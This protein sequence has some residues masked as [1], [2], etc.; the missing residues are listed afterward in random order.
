M[1]ELFLSYKI[2]LFGVTFLQSLAKCLRRKRLTSRQETWSL[3]FD[4]RQE[5]RL[6]FVPYS[7]HLTDRPVGFCDL[8]L[9]CLWRTTNYFSSFI[10]RLL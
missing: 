7:L 1:S 2:E 9:T 6:N 3:P 8:E 10:R 4:H 5:L